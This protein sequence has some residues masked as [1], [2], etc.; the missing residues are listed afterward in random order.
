M[1]EWEVGEEQ[2]L[3]QH[4]EGKNL[5]KDINGIWVWKEDKKLKYTIRSAYKI[6]MNVVSG[7]QMFMYEY[8]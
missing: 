6:L 7:E 5:I 3:M 1:F 2:H 8:F 4:L